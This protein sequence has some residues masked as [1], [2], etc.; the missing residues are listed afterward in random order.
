LEQESRRRIK[1]KWRESRPLVQ[2]QT[3]RYRGKLIWEMR[4]KPTGRGACSGHL[5]LLV[6]AAEKLPRIG[7]QQ[8]RERLDRHRIL[9][10]ASIRRGTARG[11][12][13]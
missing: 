3:L 9:R 5:V 4:A 11:S 2:A 10:D 12:R 8:A 1:A 7:E 13:G 6:A